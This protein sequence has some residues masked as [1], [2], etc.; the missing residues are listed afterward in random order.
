MLREQRADSAFDELYA[1]ESAK[2]SPEEALVTAVSR[3]SLA[4]SEKKKRRKK[5]ESKRKRC[6]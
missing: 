2:R 3:S 4:V 5:G 1:K 6:S